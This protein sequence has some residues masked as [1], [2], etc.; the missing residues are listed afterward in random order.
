M[1]RLI[2]LLTLSPTAMVTAALTYHFLCSFHE[3]PIEQGKEYVEISLLIGLFVWVF[4]WIT[5]FCQR[6]TFLN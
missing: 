3:I 6:R 1:K 2:L 4:T 5:A